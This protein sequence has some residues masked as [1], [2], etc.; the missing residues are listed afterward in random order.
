MNACFG[1]PWVHPWSWWFMGGPH[2]TQKQLRL[3]LRFITAKGDRLKQTK[4]QVHR[5]ESGETRPSIQLSLPSGVAWTAPTSF[6]QQ[7]CVMLRAKCCQLEM[8]AWALASQDFTDGQSHRHGV[9]KRLRLPPKDFSPQ[10][11]ETL[12]C[13]KDPLFPKL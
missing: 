4:E 5:A 10:K 9:P 1:G 8:L 2:G 11:I 7:Q 12:P 3:R 6:S 13:Y